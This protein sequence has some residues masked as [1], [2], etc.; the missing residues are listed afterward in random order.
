LVLE[1]SNADPAGW[2]NVDADGLRIN[3]I[4]YPGHDDITLPV[5]ILAVVE[6]MSR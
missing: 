4:G 6:F 1:S 2:L 5:D 3:V